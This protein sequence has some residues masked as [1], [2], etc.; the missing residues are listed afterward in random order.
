MKNFRNKAI[1][2][3]KIDVN[4]NAMP[5]VFIKIDVLDMQG[6][7]YYLISDQNISFGTC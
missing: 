3:N 5:N 7:Q 1:F 6:I 4:V 2:T